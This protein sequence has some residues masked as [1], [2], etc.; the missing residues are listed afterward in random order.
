[1]NDYEGSITIRGITLYGWAFNKSEPE[2]HLK[3]E[4]FADDKLIG[5]VTA[6]I[7]RQ[8]LLKAGKGNGDHGF[9]FNLVGTANRKCYIYAK[10]AGTNYFLNNFPVFFSYSCS[11]ERKNINLLK[12]FCFRPFELFEKI[13]SY[14]KGKRISSG[15]IERIEK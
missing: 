9:C 8:D 6:N 14:K 10:V 7:Y 12:K 3:I 2:K 4:L 5:T 13:N 11:S 1:M 15:H